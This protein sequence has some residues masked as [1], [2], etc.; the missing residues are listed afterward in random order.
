MDAIF[1]NPFRVLGL[2]TTASDKEISKRASDLQIYA[3]MGKKVSYETDLPFLGEIDR[4]EQSI[5]IAVQKIELPE[6]RIFYSLLWFDLNDNV[7]RH[8]IELYENG[9]NQNA[10]KVLEDGIFNNSQVIYNVGEKISDI[11]NTFQQIQYSDYNIKIFFPRKNTDVIPNSTI[12][13]RRLINTRENDQFIEI[14]EASY[15]V[16]LLDNFQI[17]FGFSLPSPSADEYEKNWHE[18]CFR[19]GFSQESGLKHFISLSR[20]GILSFVK[21]D[22]IE[23]EI[24]IDQSLLYEGKRTFL[25]INI[26]DNLIELKHN[27][28]S[29]YKAENNVKFKST[30]LMMP[31]KQSIILE[32]LVISRL[33]NRKSIILNI[34]LNDKTFSYSKNISLLYLTNVLQVKKV[35]FTLLDYFNIIGNFFHNPYFILY[36]KK[37]IGDNYNCDLSA[38]T[39]KFIHEFYFS[40]YQLVDHNEEYAELGFYNSFQRISEKAEIR[41]KEIIVGSKPHTF[42]NFIKRTI[43]RRNSYPT[44]AFEL[45]NDL[46][47][48]AT[49]FI[50]WYSKFYG[51]RTLESKS[52]SDKV[53]KEILE[54]AISLYNSINPKS[55][56][57]ANQSLKLL[58]WASDFAFGPELRDRINLN[59]TTLLKNFEIADYKIVDFAEKDR[60]RGQKPI[61]PKNTPI[62]VK[63]EN[64]SS[65]EN[66]TTKVKIDNRADP[67]NDKTEK[68]FSSDRKIDYLFARLR[69]SRQILKALVAFLV[70]Y[71]IVILIAGIVLFLIFTH[72]S[73]KPSKWVGNTLE[74]GTS[75]YDNYFGKG[76]YDYNSK[77]WIKFK[78]GNSTDVIVCLE[79]V[80]TGTTIR[81]DYIRV[82]SDYTMSNLPVGVYK[83]KVFYGKDWNPEKSLENGSIRG[84]FDS[85]SNFS[86][87]DDPKDLVNISITT[88][89][90]GISYSTYEIT[91]YT[92]SNGNMNQRNISSDDFFK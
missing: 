71:L 14:K 56:E 10:H 50:N 38:I 81:N 68:N 54:C 83:I 88:T 35:G 2:S 79:N 26:F 1:N 92:V 52:I 18:V 72:E 67:K 57:L 63:Q 12:K 43:E 20:N 60:T 84:A 8:S 13:Y 48:E 89:Y 86:V 62:E 65:K 16:E 82:G 76:I 21:S 75:P 78:N 59:I 9:D 17:G 45:A 24:Q 77:C 49:Y 42:E 66:N 46:K 11:F 64:T 7:S 90:E 69:K 44:I 61:P 25:S 30:F 58:T 47:D 6:N 28:K 34:E 23:T 51:L 32:D 27:G 36:T 4:S 19:L 41:A 53:A 73:E 70:K 91:L 3:E 31:G 22:K 15:N 55:K 37:I 29:I 39:D 74:N 80:Y 33:E 40:L 5:K 87:S 85:N